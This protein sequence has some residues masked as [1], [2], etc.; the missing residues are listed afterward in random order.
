MKDEIHYEQTTREE[1]SLNKKKSGKLARLNEKLKI[2]EKEKR[3]YLTGWQRAQ[4]DMINF[5]QRQEKQM[6]DWQ[7]LINEKLILEILPVLDT[8]DAATEVS[9]DKERE[10]YI[11]IKKQ[12]EEILRGHGL[13]KINCEEVCFNPQEHEAIECEEPPDGEKE[14]RIVSEVRRGYKLNGRVI[15]AAKVKIIKK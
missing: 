14:E 1:S 13:E 2:C 6:Q 10:N 11:L 4:A 9:Q 15:R 7:K 5:R 8:L 3:E 12:L